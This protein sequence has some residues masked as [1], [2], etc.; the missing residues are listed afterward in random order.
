MQAIDPKS[1]LVCIHDSA[2]PLISVGDVKKVGLHIFP[3]SKIAYYV[4][5]TMV[6]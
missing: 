2:R 4:K 6:D 1:E 3:L 5:K